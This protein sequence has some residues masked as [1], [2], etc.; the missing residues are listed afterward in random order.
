MPRIG[1]VALRL[2]VRALAIGG[3]LEAG[4]CS[5]PATV[6]T[7]RSADGHVI[8]SQ[9]YRQGL[10]DGPSL[11]WYDDGRIAESREYRRGNKVGTHRGWWPSGAPRFACAFVDGVAEG[12]CSEWYASGRLASLQHFTH[13]VEDG[14][15]QGWSDRGDL[16]FSYTRRDGRRYG[17]RGAVVCKPVA[18]VA[19]G[20]G[21]L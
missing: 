7:T 21:L 4:G 17:V 8:A 11:T 6:V 2:I 1:V 10:L 12:A 18:S 14:L 3:A 19:D 13:G 15:Q 9:S 5:S 16:Q 20:A